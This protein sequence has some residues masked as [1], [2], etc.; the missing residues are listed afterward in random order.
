MIMCRH[1]YSS[2]IELT[3]T[4]WLKDVKGRFDM[5]AMSQ[6]AA[7]MAVGTKDDE[8]IVVPPSS[9]FSCKKFWVAEEGELTP[10]TPQVV[11]S[12]PP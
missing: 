2:S 8:E 12:T 1:F 5:K 3:S 7:M 10:F 9:K 11:G 6:Q 4:N